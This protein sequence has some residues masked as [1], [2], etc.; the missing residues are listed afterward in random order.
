MTIKDIAKH[1]NV[2]ISMVS[3]AIN[4]SGYIREDLRQA[5]IDYAKQHH[6]QP[7]KRAVSL[8]KGSSNIVG[9]VVPYIK[10]NQFDFLPMLISQLSHLKYSWQFAMGKD[11][12]QIDFLT[13]I[14]VEM[15]LA[16][17]LTDEQMPAIENAQNKNIPVL[18]IFGHR[19]NVASIFCPHKKAIY[20]CVKT[21]VDNGHKKIAYVGLDFRITNLDLSTSHFASAKAGLLQAIDDF[22]LD[23]NIERDCVFSQDHNFDNKQ[24]ENLMAKGKYTAILGWTIYAEIAVYSAARQLGIIIGQDISFIG[25][26]GNKT[27]QGFNPPPTYFEFDYELILKNV[28]DFVLDKGVTFPKFTETGFTLQKGNSICKI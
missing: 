17:N 26:E 19:E 1:F 24:V 7:S 23:F 9:V 8:K 18:N 3:R 11:N 22:N 5:I 20:D 15:I 16:I 14:P 27:L 13:S 2:S 25:F 21:L 10:T 6:W 4:N 28:T 12:R